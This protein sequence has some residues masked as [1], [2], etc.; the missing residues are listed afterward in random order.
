MPVKLADVLRTLSRK[1]CLHT[2]LMLPWYCFC[3]FAHVPDR[4]M[5]YTCTT[6]WQHIIHQKLFQTFEDDLVK[7]ASHGE[8][9]KQAQNTS[10][11]PKTA[12]CC[13]IVSDTPPAAHL[14]T[15]PWSQAHGGSPK[16]QTCVHR[17]ENAT[18]LKRSPTIHCV[19]ITTTELSLSYIMLCIRD[20][21]QSGGKF[22]EAL[23]QK[24]TVQPS[25]T[26]LAAIHEEVVSWEI[27]YVITLW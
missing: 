10:G 12:L 27:W 25:K 8:T 16:Y 6:L 23:K 19:T 24:T 20:H 14:L 3:F 26:Y 11:T 22:S 1:R 18:S 17:D 13:L 21:G 7:Q 5:G 2:E 9:T 15:L 4:I